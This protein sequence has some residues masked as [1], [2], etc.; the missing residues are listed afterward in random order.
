MMQSLI[1]I[2]S[3]IE[4]NLID[5]K[6]DLRF[7]DKSKF[8]TPDA[9]IIHEQQI[10]NDD[11]LLEACQRE[12]NCVLSTPTP[13]YIPPE[14]LEEF[15]KYDVVVVNYDVATSTITLGTIPEF[16]NQR[17]YTDKYNTDS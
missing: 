8:R 10:I 12:Y 17:V 11:R 9:L 5:S 6:T 15:A 16:K 14:V 13:T 3:A 4:A 2:I 7:K 1:G